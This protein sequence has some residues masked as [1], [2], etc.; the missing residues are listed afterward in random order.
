MVKI[1]NPTANN[2]KQYR[3]VKDKGIHKNIKLMQMKVK[4]KDINIR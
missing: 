1:Q 4:S 3:R 2:L